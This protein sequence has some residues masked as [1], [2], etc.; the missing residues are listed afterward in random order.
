MQA[1]HKLLQSLRSRGEPTAPSA[2][3]YQRRSKR[4]SVKATKPK[5][6]LGGLDGLYDLVDSVP[7]ARQAADEATRP[8]ASKY[9]SLAKRPPAPKPRGDQPV[10]Q[11]KPAP[12]SWMT[13]VSAQDSQR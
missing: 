4:L 7:S 9:E 2:A 13:S 12:A 5:R 8:S 10:L 11:G 3:E 6:S 1:P